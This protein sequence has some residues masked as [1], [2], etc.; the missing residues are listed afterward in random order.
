[1]NYVEFLGILLLGAAV[2]VML[3]I[4]IF[5]IVV[6]HKGGFEEYDNPY[7]LL[8]QILLVTCGTF[9]FLGG[10]ITIVGA[11]LF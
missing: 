1:M 7:A 10:V 2:L 11:L 8:G 9:A 5:T 4:I 3:F 6:Q